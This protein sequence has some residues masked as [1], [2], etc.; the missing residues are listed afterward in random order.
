MSCLNINLA[1]IDF[2][3]QGKPVRAFILFES[4]FFPLL[5]LVLIVKLSSRPNSILG[6]LVSLN[7]FVVLVMLKHS[8]SP[9]RRRQQSWSIS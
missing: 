8:Y 5:P 9:M 1:F 7:I 3:N 4:V 2:R 6:K